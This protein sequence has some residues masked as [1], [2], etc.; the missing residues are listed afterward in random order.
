MDFT[1]FV[2]V[3]FGIYFVLWFFDSFFKVRDMRR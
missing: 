2:T 1:V 3:L